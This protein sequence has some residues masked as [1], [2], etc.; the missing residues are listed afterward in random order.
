MGIGFIWPRWYKLFG[1]WEHGANES[2]TDTPNT[3]LAELK[4]PYNPIEP[5]THLLIYQRGL[6]VPKRGM[7]PLPS[8]RTCGT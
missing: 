7:G 3:M 2:G 8:A 1:S 5:S 4:G 6:K